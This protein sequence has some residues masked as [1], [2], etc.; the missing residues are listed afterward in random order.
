V[1]RRAQ[2]DRSVLADEQTDLRSLVA[3]GEDR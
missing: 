3:H 1:A 2:P